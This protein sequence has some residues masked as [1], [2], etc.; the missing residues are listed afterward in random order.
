MN[1]TATRIWTF[2]TAIA[3]I[4]IVALGWFLGVSPRLA[5]ASQA[6]ADRQAVLAQNVALQATTDALAADFAA[7]DDLRDQLEEV[8]GQFP[9]YAEYA[10]FSEVFLAAVVS[11]GV[12]LDS[13]QVSVALPSSVDVVPDE[14]GQVPAG[15]LLQVPVVITV[16]GEFPLALQ[17]IESL[18]LSNRFTFVN[19]GSYTEGT[20]DRRNTVISV[21]YY[22]VSEAP[23]IVDGQ[24]PAEG[25][26]P[27]TPDPEPS[28]AATPTP[29]PTP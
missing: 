6:E 9:S 19:V 3:V 2:A 23:V 12:I 1:S 17:F 10:D 15:T 4:V 27:A 20:T 28:D 25:E 5:A 22:V 13:A 14:F 7:I 26:D 11:S 8:R 18:Q 24:A 29:T 16:N 21:F